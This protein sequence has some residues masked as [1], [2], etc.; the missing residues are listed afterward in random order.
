MHKLALPVLIAALLLA[1]CAGALAEETLTVAGTTALSGYFATDLWGSNTADADVRALLHGHSTIAWT[2]AL[3]LAVDETVLHG[4]VSTENEDGSR[5]YILQVQP[6]LCYNDGSPITAADYV[7][8][9]LLTGAPAI[10]EIGGTPQDWSHLTGYDA[11]RRGDTGVLAGVRL[12]DAYTFTL[13]VRAEVLPYFYGFAFLNITPYP[14]HVIAP[15]CAVWDDGQGAYIGRAAEVSQSAPGLSYT[16]GVFS[17]DMLRQ[18]LLDPETGYAFH[19][20]VT[21]GPYQLLGYDA[22]TG[23]ATLAINPYY[24]GNYEGQKPSIERLVYTSVHDAGAAGRLADGSIDLLHKVSNGAM[25]RAVEALLAQGAPVQAVSYPRTGLAFLSFACEMPPTDSQAVRRAVALCVN[26]EALIAGEASGAAVPVHGYYG[27]GQWMLGASDS[28]TESLNA[29]ALPYDTAQANALLDADGWVYDADGSPYAPAQGAIRHR[30]VDGTLE[31]LVLR[32]AITEESAAGNELARMLSAALPQAGVGLDIAWL[33]FSQM[34]RHY[35]RQEARTYH[36][37]FLATN[38]PY[39]FD[40]ADAFHPG[41]AY[42]GRQNTTGLRD[43]TLWQLATA[44]RNTDPEDAPGYI[45]RWLAFQRRFAEVLPLVPLYSNLYHD[46][47]TDALKGYD[48]ASHPS[49]ALAIPYAT[50][51]R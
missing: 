24:Q 41:D 1:L 15:G 48:V 9:L 26:K 34:L 6:D 11:Y 44:L 42:Q 14:I 45:D 22:Q 21:S 20:R 51:D 17:A 8:S 46:F 36:L 19:P 35:Y 33:P 27:L 31:P 16:P 12:L 39:L 38:F 49:W 3:G 32:M 29:L 4:V 5:T 30:L 13:H 47:Y 2:K 7:F 18:T 40:P 37:F 50:L 25:V 28:V 23:T 10:A 43:E